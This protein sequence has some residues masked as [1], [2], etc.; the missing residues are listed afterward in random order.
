MLLFFP[1]S[2]PLREEEGGKIREKG[3]AR[4]KQRSCAKREAVQK[5]KPCEKRK[6]VE[7]KKGNAAESSCAFPELFSPLRGEKL[8]SVDFLELIGS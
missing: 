6:R 7:K 3:I 8:V 2:P 5:E 4:Q 1:H